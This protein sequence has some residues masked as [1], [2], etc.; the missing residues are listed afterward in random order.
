MS[1]RTLVAALALLSPFSKSI[2]S[3]ID[4][5]GLQISV[6]GDLVVERAFST[7]SGALERLSPRSLEVMFY[8]PVDHRFDAVASATAHDERGEVFFEIHELWIGSSKVIP[9]GRFRLGQ[10]FPA[11]GRLQRFHQHDWPFISAPEAHTRFFDDEGIIDTGVELSY[12]LP[13]PRFF[14]LT[15]GVTSGWTF[16]H[17]HNEGAKPDIP[18][19]YSRLAT[20]FGVGGLG[21]AELG[22]NYVSRTSFEDTETNLFG[23]DF[24][25]KK[26]NARTLKYLGQSE[27]WYREETR[28]QG[29]TER[30]LGGY[31]Y[32][33]YGFNARW[34][35]GLRLDAFTVLSQKDALG[36][37]E[38]NLNFAWVPTLT[39]RSSEFATFRIAYNDKRD[40]V[41]DR[42]T[43]RDRFLQL[44]ATFTLGAHPAHTF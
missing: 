29:S 15:L 38:D 3:G 13:V 32:T 6:A 26:R 17:T 20:S 9:R 41:D 11:F 31:F 42:T 1:V 5:T 22:L 44:Q 21:D 12:L 4:A 23:L 25:T 40:V 33:Q 36:R 27:I 7:D 37:Q 43:N 10:M 24:V 28:D 19:H 8:A 35:L 30:I 14:E 18:T 39:Y 34:Q 16:G 2:A